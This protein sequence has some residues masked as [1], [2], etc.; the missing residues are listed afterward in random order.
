MTK[1]PMMPVMLPTW[2]L[3]Q[4]DAF[5]LAA[6]WTLQSFYPNTSPSTKQLYERANMSRAQLFRVLGSLERK[7]LLARRRRN[8]D[9]G[10]TLST[11]YELLIWD[12]WG[13]TA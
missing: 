1:P 6:L 4:V 7:G 12:K 8:A 3:G 11:E 5:E 10:S 9:N 2:L 13:A